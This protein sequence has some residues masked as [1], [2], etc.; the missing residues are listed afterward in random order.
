MAKHDDVHEFYVPCAAQPAFEAFTQR[1]AEWWFAEAT[2]N[3]D[4]FSHVAFEPRM[5]GAVTEVSKDGTSTHRGT[6][7][8]WV[9]GE[10][11]VFTFS[12][13]ADASNPSTIAVDFVHTGDDAARVRI[14]H[15]TGDAD[16]FSNWDGLI[17][18]YTEL[19]GVYTA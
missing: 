6:I 14:E 13:A 9:P 11:L 10:R 16:R 19:L 12:K 2:G 18:P 7:S 1:T 3:P 17:K 5:G 4:T 15:K 8:E